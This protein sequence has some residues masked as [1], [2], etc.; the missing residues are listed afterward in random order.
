MSSN[1]ESLASALVGAIQGLVSANST[2]R[3]QDRQRQ[4]VLDDLRTAYTGLES[5]R[6]QF[7]R[8]YQALVAQNTVTENARTLAESLRDTYKAQLST[9]SNTNTSL[10]N[11]KNTTEQGL[12][13]CQTTNSSLQDSWETCKKERE[14]CTTKYKACT[15][16]LDPF[17]KPNPTVTRKACYK[18][19]GTDRAM[20]IYRSKPNT[21]EF[22]YGTFDECKKFAIDHHFKYFA[23]QNGLPNGTAACFVG[24]GED[25]T[26]YGL[27]SA[28]TSTANGFSTGDLGGFYANMVYQLG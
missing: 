6:D 12:R 9:C 15:T 21:S 10:T 1:P 24:D 27:S 18:D 7:K 16:Q 26:R 13:D 14:D 19:V 11:A 5:Q 2:L 3:D 23:L 17:I 20:T 22:A 28:C 25:H 8:D 4:G